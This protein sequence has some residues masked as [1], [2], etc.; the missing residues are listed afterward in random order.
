MCGTLGREQARG[1]LQLT[2]NVRRELAKGDSATGTNGCG[3][4]RARRLDF[5]A[6]A[7]MDLVPTWPRCLWVGIA[8]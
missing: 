2:P 3:L 6:Y 4:Q 7:S 5:Q 1:A 8:P